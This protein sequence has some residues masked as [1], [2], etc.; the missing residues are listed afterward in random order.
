MRRNVKILFLIGAVWMFFLFYYMQPDS[1]QSKVR[2]LIVIS[3]VCIWNFARLVV[4][5]FIN[6]QL[7]VRLRIAATSGGV[8][9][10]CPSRL[11][12]VITAAYRTQIINI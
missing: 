7:L 8:V 12:G 1:T 6:D 2:L 10:A 9:C 3:F 4:V 11:R 5:L